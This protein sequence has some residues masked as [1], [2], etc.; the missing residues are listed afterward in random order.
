MKEPVTTRRQASIAAR[1]PGPWLKN[2]LYNKK[3]T[4]EFCTGSILLISA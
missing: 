3:Q 2:F 4:Y 1:L